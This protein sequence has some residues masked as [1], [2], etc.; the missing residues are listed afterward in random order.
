MLNEEHK[1]TRT[2]AAEQQRR[3]LDF[4]RVTWGD[5]SSIQAHESTGIYAGPDKR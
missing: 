5:Q 2:R 1:H 3:Q 4:G